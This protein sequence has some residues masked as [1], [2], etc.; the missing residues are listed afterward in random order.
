MIEVT[1]KDFETVVLQSD[2]PVLADFTTPT[3]GPCI[4]LAA[5]LKDL[6]PEYGD[7]IRFVKVN[8]E[9]SPDLAQAYDI[10]S[11]PTVLLVRKGEIRRRLLG[12]QSRSVLSE[13]LDALLGEPE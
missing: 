12:N 9:T 7:D 5:A 6:Q 8:C 2:V 1:A 4:L 10:R 3:C 13:A 11:V